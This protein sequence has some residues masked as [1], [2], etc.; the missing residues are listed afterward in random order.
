[1]PEKKDDQGHFPFYLTL[2]LDCIKITLDVILLL[3]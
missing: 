2:V 3:R 1:M